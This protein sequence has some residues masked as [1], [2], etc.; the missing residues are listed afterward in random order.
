[1]TKTQ[2]FMSG[3][4][5]SNSN[6]RERMKKSFATTTAGLLALILSAC[7]GSGGDQNV[8]NDLAASDMNMTADANNPFGQSEMTMNDRMMAAVGTDIGDTWVRKMIE[9]HQGA[10]DMSRIMLQH[11]PTADAAK[12]AQDTITKQE[13]EIGDLRKLVKAG[14]PDQQ[15]A[16]PYKAAE[17]QMHD[18]MMA[19]NGSNVTETFMRKMLAHHRGGVALS[20][21][22]L[23]GGVTGEVRAHAQKTRTGQ[24]KEA[25][26]VEAMLGGQS[27]EQ[28][29]AG[30]GAEPAEQVKAQPATAAKPATSSSARSVQPAPNTAS[31]VEPK[32]TPAPK[33]PPKTT[34]PACL[35]E[36]R[37]LGHC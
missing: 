4:G 35:P 9:H 21:V 29:M 26:V 32:A 1:M 18:A 5:V 30:A 11:S 22:A 6:R 3:H 23:N 28:A 27:Y 17:K 2:D 15:S 33:A 37:A 34:T 25:E 31:K 13:K 20:D 24:Q 8:S 36:H 16:E 12:M 19:A 14:S 7:G 10:I